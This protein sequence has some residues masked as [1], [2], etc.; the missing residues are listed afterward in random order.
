MHTFL[1]KRPVVREA[2]F[3]QKLVG[4]NLN[5]PHILRRACLLTDFV[6]GPLTGWY[7]VAFVFFDFIAEPDRNC[8]EVSTG[9]FYRPFE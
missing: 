9:W 4:T 5:F 8:L 3:L 6:P 7:L 1:K 2:S